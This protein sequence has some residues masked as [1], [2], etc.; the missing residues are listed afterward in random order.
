[1]YIPTEEIMKLR[2]IARHRARIRRMDTKIK[3]TIKAY[4]L[5]DGIKYP[6]KMWSKEGMLFLK[7]QNN[8]DIN[9]LLEIH[10]SLIKQINEV[11]TRV[12]KI[13]RNTEITRILQTFPGIGY[14]GSVMIAAEIG[15]V[16]RFDS[17]KSLVM[18]AGLCP[19]IY[20]SAKTNRNVKQTSYNHWLKWIVYECS[21][22]AVMLNTKY[23]NHYYKLKQ[24][25]GKC[26]ARRSTARKML[27]DIYHAMKTETTYKS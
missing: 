14:Y 19:G 2:D 24:R 26:V 18:Y 8:P 6:K 27:S 3:Q 13:S 22:R 7:S 16:K 25:K 12:T 4:L 17:P 9:N 23:T 10:A 15:D 1:V 11:T 21:G 20:Q 5:R